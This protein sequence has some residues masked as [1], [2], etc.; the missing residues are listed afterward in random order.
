MSRVLLLS[1]NTA[2]SPYEVYP[3]GMSVVAG[4]L[5][6]KGHEVR[7]F[8]FQRKMAGPAKRIAGTPTGARS[9]SKVKTLGISIK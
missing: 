8:D 6:K 7:Q 2:G 4:A 5:E 9:M 3:L 1:T